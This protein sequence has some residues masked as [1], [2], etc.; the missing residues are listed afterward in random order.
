MARSVVLVSHIVPARE[1]SIL[2]GV[3]MGAKLLSEGDT[4]RRII[5][6]SAMVLGVAALAFG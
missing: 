1:I 4:K 6:T 5:A 3:V 2:T